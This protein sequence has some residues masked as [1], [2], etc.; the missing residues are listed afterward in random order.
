MVLAGV[1]T[2][3]GE[4][5]VRILWGK[6]TLRNLDAS[7]QKNFYEGLPMVADFHSLSIARK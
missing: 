3:K 4:E 2:S 5:F 1:S 6:K 7:A